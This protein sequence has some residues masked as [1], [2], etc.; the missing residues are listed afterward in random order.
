MN[1]STFIL[2]PPSSGTHSLELSRNLYLDSVS[3]PIFIPGAWGRKNLVE[4]FGFV[5]L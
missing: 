1:S 5:Y 4:E 2:N 3:L